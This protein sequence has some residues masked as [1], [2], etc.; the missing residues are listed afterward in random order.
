MF[1]AVVA[2]AEPRD[3][4][5]KRLATARAAQGE[6][7]G[8]SGVT[9]D[10]LSHGY[11]PPLDRTMFGQSAKGEEAKRLG[12]IADRRKGIRIAKQGDKS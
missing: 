12:E 11:Q 1:A 6:S 4:I 5:A 7:E 10:P 2:G 3:V 8:K 9:D